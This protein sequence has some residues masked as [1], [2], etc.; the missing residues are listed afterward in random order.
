MKTFLPHLG[1]GLAGER[2]TSLQALLA[3]D[4]RKAARSSPWCV[5]ILE[6]LPATNRAPI[7]CCLRRVTEHF[8]IACARLTE[9]RFTKSYFLK[10][11]FFKIPFYFLWP[12]ASLSR[13]RGVIKGTG[14]P[15]LSQGLMRKGSRQDSWQVL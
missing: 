15:K 8:T 2:P 5:L 4:S 9:I 13:E 10:D 12:S 11:R 7:H 6:A 1:R 14:A 3:I